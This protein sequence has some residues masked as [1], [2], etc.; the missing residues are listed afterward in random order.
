MKLKDLIGNPNTLAVQQDD[1]SYRPFPVEDRH[2]LDRLLEQHKAGSLT[3]GTYTVV[4]DTAKTLVFDID[5]EPVAYQTQGI[6]DALS[7]LGVP[8]ECMGTEF[9]GKK[10]E[11]VWVVLGGFRPAAELRR[12]GRAAL[13]LSGV[14]C[15]V[16][17]KQDSARE[18]GN[19]VKLPL[20]L[21]RV[22]GKRSKWITAPKRALTK[23]EFEAILAELPP[24]PP[25]A[26]GEVYEPFPCLAAI[27]KGLGEGGRNNGLFH[28]TV[29]MRKG[30]L[31]EPYLSSLVHAVNAEFDP[32]LDDVEVDAILNSSQHSGPL[33]NSLPE[34]LHCGEA[35]IVKRSPGLVIKPGQ[36][37]HAGPG[38][39]IVVTCINRV[40][41]LVE[42]AHPDLAG[43]KGVLE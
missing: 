28:F 21:H 34:D 20:G 36:V 31:V 11:H 32:P 3:F 10:G 30:G 43:G 15:E 12:V 8:S 9:S 42:I 7:K 39:N 38:Q 24:E 41:K 19:L 17:P 27:Q 25:K 40:G 29:M 2:H 18:L 14:S 33:C 13:A 22:S 35:C 6:R 5:T 4:G 37:R 16:F 23:A 26:A 1:G